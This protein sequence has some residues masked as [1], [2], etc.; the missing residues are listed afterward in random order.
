M[1][2]ALVGPVHGGAH[3]WPFSAPPDDVT[4][5]GYVQE[6]FFLTGTA[7]GYEPEPDTERSVDG[8]WSLRPARTAP[9]T[10]RLLVIRPA[11]ASR[12]NGT[13]IVNWQNVT[14]GF[15]IGTTS[16]DI[17]ANGFAWVGVSAQRAGI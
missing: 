16:A 8:K 12:F 2:A 10:T 6:E 15:E 7:T 13:V 1:S 17:L 4:S 5:M 14:A 11:D 3:G 9:F